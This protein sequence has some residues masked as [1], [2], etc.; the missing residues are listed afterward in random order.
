[1]FPERQYQKGLPVCLD[2]LQRVSQNTA[3]F[4]KGSQNISA[5]LSMKITLMDPNLV[6][7]FFDNNFF[8]PNYVGAH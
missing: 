1:M 2:I 6:R 8:D 3:V 5:Q 4:I 7:N